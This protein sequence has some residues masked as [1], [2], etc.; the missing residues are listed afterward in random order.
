MTEGPDEQLTA[1]QHGAADGRVRDPVCGMEIDPHA[2]AHHAE[3][4]GQAYHFCS[5]GCRAKF[6]AEPQRYVGDKRADAPAPPPD[7]MWTCPMHPQIRRHGPGTCPICGMA[8]EPEQASLD[9][10]P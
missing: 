1:E 5:A 2:T 10:A 7:A 3:Y 6:V 9:D 8:L 4:A